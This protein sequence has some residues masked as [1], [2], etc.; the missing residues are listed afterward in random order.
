MTPVAAAEILIAAELLQ[1]GVVAKKHKG[2]NCPFLIL[3]YERKRDQ[4][5]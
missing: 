2:Q 3:F 4:P 5:K 1:I